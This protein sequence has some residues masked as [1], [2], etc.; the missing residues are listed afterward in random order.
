[1]TTLTEQLT[2]YLEDAHSIEVQALAQLRTA[3]DIA[4]DPELSA[5]YREH[6][7][8]T[9]GHER[10]TRSAL[11]TRD[12]KPAR[13]KDAVMAIGGEGFVVFAPPPPGPPGQPDPPPPPYEAARPAPLP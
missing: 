1:M 2:K 8:E 10:A 3:P 4:G 12:A 9:E 5:I 11:E 6:L 13:T 7:V